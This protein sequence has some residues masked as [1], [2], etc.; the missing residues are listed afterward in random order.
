MEVPQKIEN[1][2]FPGGPGSSLVAQ[3]VKNSPAVW[4][5]PGFD[6]LV[7]KIPWRSEQLPTPVFWPGEFYGLYSPWDLKESDTT[8][9]LSLSG[10]PVVK[11]LPSNAGDTGFILGGG[12]KIPHSVE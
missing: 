12:T 7:G 3:L 11:K 6:P 4:K 8:E 9:L 1:R 2:D 10:S 5:I